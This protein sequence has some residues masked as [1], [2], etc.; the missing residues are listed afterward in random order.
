MYAQRNAA[1]KEARTVVG[2]ANIMLHAEHRA[3]DVDTFG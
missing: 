3:N 1:G 2:G